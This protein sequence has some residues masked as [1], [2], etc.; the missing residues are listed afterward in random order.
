[1]G[2]RSGGGGGGRGA[3]GIRGNRP[4]STKTARGVTKLMKTFASLERKMF[5]DKYGFYPDD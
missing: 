5:Y 3:G 4:M 1:M 2:A